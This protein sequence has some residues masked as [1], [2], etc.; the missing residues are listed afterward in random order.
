MAYAGLTTE[1]VNKRVAAHKVNVIEDDT[2]MSVKD[3]IRGNVLTYFNAI[4]AILGLLRII[5][6]SF[7]NLTFLLV[8]V[9]SMVD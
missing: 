5:A 7:K 3:I 4:F 8:V 6:G 2:S 9:A 1:E